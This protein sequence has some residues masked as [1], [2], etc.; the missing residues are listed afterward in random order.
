[1]LFIGD[2]W[3][4]A[5]HDIEL[6]D[7]SGRLLTRRRLPEGLADMTM[8]HEL[9]AE[10]LDPT[11]EPDQVQVGIETERGPWVQALLAAGYR[12]AVAG[13]GVPGVRGVVGPGP[14]PAVVSGQGSSGVGAAGGA[15]VAETPSG[16]S[17]GVV[18]AALVHADQR[19]DP[20]AGSGD[21]AAPGAGCAR[22]SESDRRQQPGGCRGGAGVRGVVADRAQGAGRGSGPLAAGA[23]ADEQVGDRRDPVPVGPLGARRDHLEA[24]GSVADQL[25]RLLGRWAGIVAGVGSWPHRRLRPGLARGADPAVSGRDQDRGDRPVG[26][27][28]R[29]GSGPRSLGWRSR[30]TS[31]IWSPLPTRW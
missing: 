23:G 24:V 18:P 30:S 26:A 5:H 19:R 13:G 28:M 20:A 4:E 9:I 7:D 25:R 12:D 11:G 3:A 10:H 22:A 6:E 8:L 15:V 16:L 29:R 21:R 1:M 27:V 31:G 2:D 17:G 14:G